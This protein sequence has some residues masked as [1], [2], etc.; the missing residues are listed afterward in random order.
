MLFGFL[1]ISMLIFAFRRFGTVAGSTF[2]EVQPR[3]TAVTVL[4]VSL[5]TDRYLRCF[6][7]CCGAVW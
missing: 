5:V 6:P 3:S 4:S 1:K 7:M 2:R